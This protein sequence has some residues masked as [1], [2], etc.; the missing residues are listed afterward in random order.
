MDRFRSLRHPAF[1]VF[2]IG[3]LVSVLGTWMQSVAQGW[4]MHRLTESAWMLGLLAGA[5]F[6]PVTLFSLWAG[7]VADRMDK[8]RMIL[9]T[10]VLSMLQAVTLALVVTLGIVEPWMVLVLAL[11]F[12]VVSAFDL[13]ARQ[14]FVADLVPREDMSNAIALNSTAFNT[15]RVFGPAIAGVL[16]ATAGEAACFWINALSYLAVILSLVRIDLPRR[17]LARSSLAETLARLNEGLRYAWSTRPVRNLLVLLAIAAGLG[18]QYGPLLPVY[19]RELLHAGPGVYGLLTSAFGL[20]ALLAA[21][22][23]TR[24]H[25][26]WGLR[27]NL[28]LGLTTAGIGMGVFAWSRYLPLSLA[29]GFAAGF[30][31]ILYVATTNTLIQ[32]TIEDRYRGRVMSLYTFMF[33]GTSPLGALMAG[34]IAQRF[35]APVATSVCA[36]LLLGCALWMSNRLRVLAAQERAQ[37]PPDYPQADAVR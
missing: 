28:L 3:Q 18:F 22:L 20:G 35:G 6:L 13:P 17:D 37:S 10:Q 23:M 34:V 5:Q 2:W 24:H 11:L 27:R 32:L 29:M 4:L 7:V 8:R 15:A 19:A 21:L 30:G 16:L 25:D 36:L 26:R 12:G 33:I 14:A 1:R 9:V 31:L